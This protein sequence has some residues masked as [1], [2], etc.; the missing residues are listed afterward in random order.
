VA[1]FNAAYRRSVRRP[2]GAWLQ[3]T[4]SERAIWFATALLTAS[5]LA[6]L[7]QIVVYLLEADVQYVRAQTSAE[8]EARRGAW[9]RHIAFIGTA[10]FTAIW[11]WPPI[12]SA[13]PRLE[14]SR[15]GLVVAGTAAGLVFWTLAPFA[16]TRLHVANSAWLSLAPTTL[17]LSLVFA[18]SFL[19]P[20]LAL[21]RLSP[22]TFSTRSGLG[23]A[24]Q[25][26]D[27]PDV[28]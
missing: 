2:R 7:S 17:L 20:R 25:Q 5:C 14:V 10:L 6:V 8:L 16:L 22:G 18:L 26:A 27:E 24:A 3:S 15:S 12:A 23:A 9:S 28:E 4:L 19:L 21:P 13:I 1:L 11:S